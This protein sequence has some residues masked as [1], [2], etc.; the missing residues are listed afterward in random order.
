[1]NMGVDDPIEPSRA[2]VKIVRHQTSHDYATASFRGQLTVQLSKRDSFNWETPVQF[3]YNHCIQIEDKP[4]EAKSEGL[5]NGMLGRELPAQLNLALVRSWI[6]TCDLRHGPHC[7]NQSFLGISE[8][9]RDLKVFDIRTLR[10]VDAATHCRFIAL[11]YVWG[12]S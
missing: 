4:I 11:S 1:M 7:Q 10:V 6:A 5:S 12:A 3:R 8:W 9:P 2:L